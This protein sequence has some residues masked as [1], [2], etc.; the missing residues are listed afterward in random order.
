[1]SSVDPEGALNMYRESGDWDKCLELAEKQGG[2]ILAKYVALY[3]A[4]LIKTNAPL[5]ALKLF[6]KYGAP[7]NPQVHTHT[8]TYTHTSQFS[9]LCSTRFF[10]KNF[11]IYKR[12]CVE[13]YGSQLEGSSAYSTFATLRNI[14]LSLVRIE[15]YIIMTSL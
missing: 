5:S 1:M 4:E 7:A 2:A 3:A 12:L 14:L 9:N 6:T 15:Y 8:Y 13:V 10:L 11:N